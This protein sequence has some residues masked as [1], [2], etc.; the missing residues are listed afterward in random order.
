MSKDTKPPAELWANTFRAANEKGPYSLAFKELAAFCVADGIKPLD[1][2]DAVLRRFR[3]FLRENDHDTNRAGSK[4][5]EA[6]HV[7]YHLR[8][9]RDTAGLIPDRGIRP[10]RGARQLQL[11]SL[12]PQWCSDL[13]F[14]RQ[15][16]NGHRAKSAQDAAE[17]VVLNLIEI[18]GK[19]S[20]PIKS[21]DEL[22]QL[23]TFSDLYEV[24]FGKTDEKN[25]HEAAYRF[26][27]L[28]IRYHEARGGRD[29]LVE[30]FEAARNRMGTRKR[31]IA[32]RDL[33]RAGQIDDETW[34]AM[35]VEAIRRLHVA[36]ASPAKKRKD[37]AAR[38]GLYVMVLSITGRTRLAVCEAKF[39][40]PLEASDNEPS[41]EAAILVDNTPVPLGPAHVAAI[42]AWRRSRH[43]CWGIDN[44]LV[45]AGR[46]GS[47]PNESSF[48]TTTKGFG[49]LFNVDITPR[50]LRLDVVSKLADKKVPAGQIQ[51][52]LG[53]KQLINLK[54]QFRQLIAERSAELFGKAVVDGA[55]PKKNDTEEWGDD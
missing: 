5:A 37:D 23:N 14:I 51:S 10:P 54:S 53:I 29:E 7:I 8:Q 43:N 42:A 17:R 24:K 45:F 39:A 34:T 50:T 26:L 40:L 16:L 1:L 2:N 49:T 3:K 4:V 6:R 52:H 48:T 30:Q 11:A 25:L 33:D 44:R 47:A 19:F 55:G 28:A 36:A 32:P 13:T 38:V 21:A 15:V 9:H 12:N 18:T 27:G 31:D 20:P 41:A 46:D 22:F 35:Q